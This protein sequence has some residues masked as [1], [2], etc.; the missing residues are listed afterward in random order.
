MESLVLMTAGAA[1]AAAS[2]GAIAI[3]LASPSLWSERGKESGVQVTLVPSP[4]FSF[5]S[6]SGDSVCV[7]LI[8]R[9]ACGGVESGGDASEAAGCSS[10]DAVA[11]RP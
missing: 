11:K 4:S 9:L 8:D 6:F 2:G 7:W 10:L 1:A 5:S 3:T